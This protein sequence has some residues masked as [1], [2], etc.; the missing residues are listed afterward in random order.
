MEIVTIPVAVP[1]CGVPVAIPYGSKSSFKPARVQARIVGGRILQP[2]LSC[3]TEE[4]NAAIQARP[5]SVRPRYTVG[6]FQ[7]EH[8]RVARK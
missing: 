3:L 7:P 1:L 8:L 5:G 2:A 6:R 4:V